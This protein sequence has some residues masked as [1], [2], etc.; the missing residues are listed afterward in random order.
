MDG[1]GVVHSHKILCSVEVKVSS[2]HENMHT[3]QT[4]NQ[5][6]NHMYETPG[7]YPQHNQVPSMLTHVV[8]T[9]CYKLQVGLLCI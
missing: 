4:R 2:E 5:A 8:I 6:Q 3:N 1:L 9:Q 7:F